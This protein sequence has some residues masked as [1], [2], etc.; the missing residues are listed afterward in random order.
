MHTIDE[1]GGRRFQAPRFWLVTDVELVARSH[2]QRGAPDAANAVFRAGFEQFP[3]SVYILLCYVR[4]LASVGNT[5]MA[6]A[7]LDQ[8]LALPARADLRFV[9]Y[10]KLRE[11]E[12]AQ[13]AHGLTVGA[14]DLISYVQFETKLRTA[15]AHHKAAI[16]ALSN[17]WRTLLRSDRN[18]LARSAKLI[19]RIDAAER[20]ANDCYRELILKYPTAPGLLVSYAA[21]LDQVSN[22]PV[23]ADRFLRRAKHVAT[24]N[25]DDTGDGGVGPHATETEAEHRED[26]GVGVVNSAV[27]AIVTLGSM[28]QITSFNAQA[29]KLYGYTSHAADK[30]IRGESFARAL[31]AQP[32]SEWH[33]V[34]LSSA[35]SIPRVF[36]LDALATDGSTFPISFSIVRMSS[37]TGQAAASSAAYVAVIRP[38]AASDE[39]IALYVSP[40]GSVTACSGRPE[41]MLSMNPRQ[42]VSSP[43]HTLFPSDTRGM[44]ALTSWLGTDSATSGSLDPHV[45]IIRHRNGRRLPCVISGSW[46]GG[47]G[48]AWIGMLVVEPIASYSIDILVSNGGKVI[49]VSD[50]IARAL[51]GVSE[52]ELLGSDLSLALDIPPQVSPSALPSAISRATSL[53]ADA[54]LS[55]LE[56]GPARTTSLANS[57]FRKPAEVAALHAAV[58]NSRTGD[59][60]SPLPLLVESVP[61]AEAGRGIC[62]VRSRPHPLSGTHVYMAAVAAP[63]G[64]GG[65]FRVM[66]L[67]LTAQANAVTISTPIPPPPPV[68]MSAPEPTLATSEPDLHF[69]TQENSESPRRRNG[70]SVRGSS[71]GAPPSRRARSTLD[72]PASVIRRRSVSRSRGDS[73]DTNSSMVLP[74]EK[75][76]DTELPCASPSSLPARSRRKSTAEGS[77]FSLSTASVGMYGGR[78]RR[79][80]GGRGGEDDDETGSMLSVPEQRMV[81]AARARIAARR[82]VAQQADSDVS[83]SLRAL[84]R[85]ASDDITR[86]S[87]RMFGIIALVVVLCIAVFA[88]SEVLLIR[89]ELRPERAR[90][91][92]IR[93]QKTVRVVSDIQSLYLLDRVEVVTETSPMPGAS[94]TCTCARSTSWSR[95]RWTTWATTRSSP[96]PSSRRSMPPSTSSWSTTTS[97][98]TPAG[99]MIRPAGST[100]STRAIPRL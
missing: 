38:R 23:L 94:R 19:A 87:R 12:Q 32:Y 26:G 61:G 66:F 71:P 63:E 49:A 34:I 88:M 81:S 97:C 91:A 98:L 56:L 20:S 72:R 51:W 37:H 29:R 50:A 48:A 95:A 68:I 9:R 35:S 25:A 54:I 17:F 79:H 59:S 76:T 36:L 55:S 5:A 28:G 82:R 3:D 70:F 2:I 30:E 96:L 46:L 65:N 24:I 44:A 99:S 90:E 75:V 4:F 22:K 39:R 93:L 52:L 84:R 16:S 10:R 92:T 74:L 86:L 33:E 31:F 6:H 62:I 21:F 100:S 69:H 80:R 83:T 45:R 7:Y 8:S 78:S 77:L 15:R 89:A 13:L 85:S 73:A 43:M 27:D 41:P 53:R 42:L 64:V 40:A 1:V 14:M 67:P 58:A 57:W 18:F 47:S 11:V 60:A